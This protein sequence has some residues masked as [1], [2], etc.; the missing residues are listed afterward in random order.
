MLGTALSRQLQGKCEVYGYSSRDLDI[1]SATGVSRLLSELRPD[2]VLHAAGFTRVDE[3]EAR[4]EEAFRV[5]ALGTRNVASAAYQAGSALLY[6]STDY[7]FDGESRRPYR[8]WDPPRP[9]NTYGESKLLGEDFVRSLCPR[10]LIV[11]TS[12]LFGRGGSHFVDKILQAARRHDRLEVVADQRGSPTY[13]E[14]LAHASVK[15]L[16]AGARGTYHVTNSGECSWYELAQAALA[17]RGLKVELDKTDSATYGAPA[18]RPSF[19]VLDNFW[20]RLEGWSPL[21]SW[22]EALTEFLGG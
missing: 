8:E 4:P 21:R 5:N 11:R 7:V 14:D 19:S 15:L 22:K 17:I 16:L 2:W 12:W 10:H 18:R 3:A 20:Y 6:Y 9:L 1:T 13:S